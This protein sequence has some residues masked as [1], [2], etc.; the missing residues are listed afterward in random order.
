MESNM[1]TDL[2][3][4][5]EQSAAR[6]SHLCPRQVLGVRMAQAALTILGLE[7]P[8]TKQTALVIV[9]TD[10]CFADGVEV[11]S[12]AT[13]GHRTLRVNDFGKVAVT[14]VDVRS[15]RAL[16]LSPLPGLRGRASAYA[17]QEARH[18]FAQLAAYQVMPDSEMFRVQ[19]V[20]LNPGLEALLSRPGLRTECEVCGEEI[21]NER[22]VRRDGMVM[23]RACAGASYYSIESELVALDALAVQALA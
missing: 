15:C 16:R 4:L 1:N 7:A 13:V 8:V 6:H 20:S 22:E 17:P 10:G 5:L 18:Y 19:A 12:G 11:A 21:I 23:C 3:T 14:V 9:E 2:T